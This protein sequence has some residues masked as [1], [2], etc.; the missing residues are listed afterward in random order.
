[1][2]IVPIPTQFLD[3]PTDPVAIATS[4]EVSVPSRPGLRSKGSAASAWAAWEASESAA[5]G[6]EF[7][8]YVSSWTQGTAAQ[9]LREPW[10]ATSVRPSALDV[11]ERLC[12]HLEAA[13]HGAHVTYL[14]ALEQARRGVIEELRGARRPATKTDKRQSDAATGSA[15]PVASS[16]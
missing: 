11:Q 5:C 13:A 2:S 1:M 9:L 6:S 15:F 10:P 7:L 3:A 8:R 4:P 14:G 16:A 12:R